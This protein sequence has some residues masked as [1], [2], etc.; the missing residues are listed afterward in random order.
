MDDEGLDGG[1]QISQTLLKEIEESRLSIA[2]FSGKLRIFQ[3]V[4]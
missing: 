4:S 1:N 2:F 3:V